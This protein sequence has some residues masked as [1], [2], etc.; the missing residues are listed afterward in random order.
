[1]A[2]PQRGLLSEMATEYDVGLRIGLDLIHVLEYG[3]KAAKAF[4]PRAPLAAATWVT[5][6]LEDLLRGRRRQ[7]A[8]SLRRRA[9]ERRLTETQRAP[10]EQCAHDLRTYADFVHYDASLAAGFPLATGVSEGACRH[11]VQDR[12]AVTGAR[13]SLAGAEAVL[14]LRSL[15]SRGDFEAYWPFQLEQACTRHHAAH[16]AKGNVPTPT[17][18]VK[19]QERGSHLQLVK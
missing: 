7:V 14:R 19:R 5:A 12:M 16:Y 2:P 18:P 1:M 11:L 8:A 10:G 13:W 15:W 9:T 4:H 3:W 17:S 6:R